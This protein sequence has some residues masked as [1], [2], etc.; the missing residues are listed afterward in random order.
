MT[1]HSATD[2]AVQAVLP[3]TETVSQVAAEISRLYAVFDEVAVD[4][5]SEYI[6]QRLDGEEGVTWD[7]FPRFGFLQRPTPYVAAIARREGAILLG[8]GYDM[9]WELHNQYRLTKVSMLVSS[10]GDSFVRTDAVSVRRA[11]RGYNPG[12]EHIVVGDR[13]LKAGYDHDGPMPT[14][15]T[16]GKL[17]WSVSRDWVNGTFHP[18]TGVDSELQRNIK[19]LRAY[20]LTAAPV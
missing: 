8:A 10:G 19:D 16:D 2:A 12:S 18:V 7:M 17:A 11:S 14:T 13:V 4:L 5:T 3:L 9:W 6:K 1:T 15:G 20:E